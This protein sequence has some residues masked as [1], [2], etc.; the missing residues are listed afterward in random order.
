MDGTA[1]IDIV[2]GGTDQDATTIAAFLI[3]SGVAYQVNPGAAHKYFHRRRER[4][5]LANAQ[6]D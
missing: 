3:P 1:S 5:G 4:S 6:L 2:T